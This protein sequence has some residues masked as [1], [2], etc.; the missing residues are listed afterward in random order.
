[1]ELNKYI[2]ITKWSDH[3]VGIAILFNYFHGIEATLKGFISHYEHAPK[4]HKLTHL[5]DKFNNLF[6][7]T[8]VTPLVWRHTKGLDADSPLGRFFSANIISVDDWYQALK[9]PESINGEAFI[10]TELMY[11][12]LKSLPFWEEISDNASRLC[13]EAHLLAEKLESGLSTNKD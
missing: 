8:P 9:Y 7:G 2:E 13:D 12:G 6:P 5:L 11:G 3:A 4:N 10:H 1:M